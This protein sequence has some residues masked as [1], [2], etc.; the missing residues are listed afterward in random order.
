MNSAP[1]ERDS[2]RW[3]ACVIETD[4][5]PTGPRGI[6]G[7]STQGRDLTGKKRNSKKKR[8]KSQITVKRNKQSTLNTEIRRPNTARLRM[9]ERTMITQTPMC[10]AEQ[11]LLLFGYCLTYFYFFDL[12]QLQIPL[13]FI[14]SFH[15]NV[16]PVSGVLAGEYLA[17]G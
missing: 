6:T 8:K 13:G 16:H 5:S 9:L 7:G 17:T 3:K 10:K 11:L 12:K 4:C 14:L 2:G 15:F 1:S